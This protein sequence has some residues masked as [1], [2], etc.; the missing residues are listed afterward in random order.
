MEDLVQWPVINQFFIGEPEAT[1]ESN[2]KTFGEK[3]GAFV[4]AIDPRIKGGMLQR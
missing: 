2:T 3:Q 4:V 1:A